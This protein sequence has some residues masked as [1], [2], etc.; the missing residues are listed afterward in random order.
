M[1]RY[2]YSLI[3]FLGGELVGRICSRVTDKGAVYDDNI[4]D[5]SKE[6]DMVEQTQENHEIKQTKY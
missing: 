1:I 2:E 6:N 5:D 3:F 4:I